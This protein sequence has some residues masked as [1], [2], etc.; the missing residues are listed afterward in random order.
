[1]KKLLVIS[2]LLLSLCNMNVVRCAL[3]HF[4]D[5]SGDGMSRVVVS[6]DA[7]L[8]DQADHANHLCR[9]TRYIRAIIDGYAAGPHLLP[10]IEAH[11][12]KLVFEGYFT[13]GVKISTK[14]K[15]FRRMLREFPL[16]HRLI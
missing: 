5:N 15:Y 16:E 13:K 4:G 8:R 2:I 7:E 6:E 14:K 1:M 11:Y 9:L 3:M 10:R 12:S